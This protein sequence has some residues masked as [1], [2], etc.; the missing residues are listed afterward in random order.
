MKSV[1]AFVFVHAV[2]LVVAS[3]I[4]FDDAESQQSIRIIRYVLSI[5]MPGAMGQREQDSFGVNLQRPR[6]SSSTLQRKIDPFHC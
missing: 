5:F 1:T 4:Q 3:T 6:H 2:G